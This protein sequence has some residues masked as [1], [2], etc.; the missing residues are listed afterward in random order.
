LFDSSIFGLCHQCDL[1]FE[2]C[3]VV[4]I[5]LVERATVEQELN[6]IARGILKCQDLKKTSKRET[7]LKTY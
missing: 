3:K 6:K 2:V 4:S 1:L 5:Q 7:H